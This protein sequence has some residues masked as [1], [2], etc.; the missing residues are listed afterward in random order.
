[1]GE[2]RE[3]VKVIILCACERR[4]EC[5]CFLSFFFFFLS[6]RWRN[7]P[8]GDSTRL[9]SPPC[10]TTYSILFLQHS[11][12]L[13]RGTP[14]PPLMLPSTNGCWCVALVL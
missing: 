4:V 1:M 5:N 14:V 9:V 8:R 3:A 7:D 6:S 2:R 13:H 12:R 11:T 10:G